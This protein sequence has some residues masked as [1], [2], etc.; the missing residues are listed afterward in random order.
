M[1]RKMNKAIAGYHMLMLLSNVDGDINAKE[2]SLIVDYLRETFPFRVNLDNEI[3]IISKLSRE[4]Y[5]PHFTK[6]MDDFYFDSLPEE[7]AGFV[8]FAI[9]LVKADKKISKEE[10]VFLNELLNGWDPDAE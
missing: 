5:L 8:N 2:G 10:N 6:A 3:D 1:E 4:E 9:N 7:R